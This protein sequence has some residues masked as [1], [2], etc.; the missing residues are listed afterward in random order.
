M[1]AAVAAANPRTVV[2]LQTGGPVE[3]P[4]LADVA[5]VLEA[6]YPGQEA[7]N[8][9]ADVLTG[10]AEPGGRLP[11][12]FPV[13]WND[14]P[15]HSQDR[16]VYPGLNGKVRYEEGVFIGYRHYER[17]GIAPLFPFGFGLSYTSFALTDLAIEDADFDKHGNVTVWV[18]VTNTGDRTGSEVVQLY[19]GDDAASVPR[20]KKELKAFAKVELSPGEPRRLRLDLSGRD[21]AFYSVEAKHWLLEPGG[22]S[23]MVGTSA[24]AI[25]LSAQIGRTTTLMLPV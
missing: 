5:A 11:Q 24:T 3:M 9:I 19:V 17:Q 21:F 23:V 22:F 18:T 15:T 12:S 6:W 7:G 16:E 14:N 1:I 10:K 13:K 2:V 25:T 20:P 8:A 4:W